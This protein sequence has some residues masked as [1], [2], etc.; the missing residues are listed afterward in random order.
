MVGVTTGIKA[1]DVVNPTVSMTAPPA[2]NVSGIVTL[3]VT[4]ADNDRIASIQYKLDGVNIGSPV[5]AS[6]WQ[7]AHDT[8]SVANG[9]HTY[10]AVATD[11]VGLQTTSNSI[12]VTMHNNPAVSLTQPPNGGTISGGYTLAATVTNYGTGLTVQFKIDGVNVGP[13]MTAAPFQY[14]IDTHMYTAGAHTFTVVATDGQGNSTTVNN[15]ATI[16]QAVPAA[17]VA[18]LGDYG[19]WHDAYWSDSSFID[20]GYDTSRQDP[21]GPDGTQGNWI[22]TTINA[23]IGYATLPGNPNP[24]YYQMR[25]WLQTGR[26]EGGSGGNVVYIDVYLGGTWY[27]QFWANGPGYTNIGPIANVN[28]GEQFGAKRWCTQPGTNNCFTLG[29]GCYYDFVPKYGS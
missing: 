18:M 20:A 11:R 1:K 4:T 22:W 10:S 26:C 9:A 24:T 3:G 6:P 27:N 2:G 16:S 13:A 7:L 8:R 12:A 28:G 23:K 19:I 29:V 17:G 15:T 14:A 5:T 25:A 21:G